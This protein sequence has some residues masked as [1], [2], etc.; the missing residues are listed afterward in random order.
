MTTQT[1]ESRIDIRKKIVLDLKKSKGLE[2]QKAQVILALDFSGSMDHLYRTGKVQEL[3]E[4]MLP[5]GL[6]FDDN[7]EV[8]FYLFESG[9]KKLP[10]NI[11][12]ANVNG[13]INNKVMGKYSMGGTN[14]APVINAIVKDFANAQS[15][16]FLS[17]GKGKT[18]PT[19]DNPVYV[20]FVT[21]GENS[22]KRE[23]EEAI[24][25]A[26]KS[27]IF[28]QFVGIGNAGFYFLDKLDNLSGRNIDN[29]NFFKVPDLS[30]KSDDDLYSL[31]LNEF[32][33][34]IN[35]ARNKRLIK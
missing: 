4:R 3:V 22:D 33:S 20:I 12:L 30:T 25:E 28:F 24:I 27:G 34:F 2:N 9:V 11:T 26:S 29:A 19:L 15:G 18:Y 17:F 14:Y 16:G 6:A 7:G 23:A 8:D 1:L 35:E 32:P 5:L 21:D 10:E 31:L 13:Y